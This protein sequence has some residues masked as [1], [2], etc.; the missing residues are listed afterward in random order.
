MGATLKQLLLKKLEQLHQPRE[1]K[2]IHIAV[3]GSILDLLSEGFI[4][5]HESGKKQFLIAE[6]FKVLSTLSINICD[7]K[8]IAIVMSCH[9]KKYDSF[10]STL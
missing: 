9:P 8:S 4:E 3:T 1:I 2:S 5:R 7:T 6:F 10:Y